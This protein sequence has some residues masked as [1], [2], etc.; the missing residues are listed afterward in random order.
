MGFVEAFQPF[1]SSDDLQEDFPSKVA[2]IV[3]ISFYS[4]LCQSY[5]VQF[6]DLLSFW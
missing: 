4:F 3:N 2:L 6:K 5:V 1:E